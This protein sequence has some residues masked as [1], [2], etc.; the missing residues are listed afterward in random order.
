[1]SSATGL[2]YLRARYY[3]PTTT[4]F[5]SVDPLAATTGEHYNFGS[6]DP[7]NRN[8]PTGMISV[9]F[10]LSASAGLFFG[11]FGQVCVVGARN[12]VDGS[13]T[14]GF[15]ETG[16]AGVQTPSLSAGANLQVS[17]A[18]SVDQLGGPFTYGGL[19]VLEPASIGGGAF[20]GKS[21]G[22]PGDHVI[23]GELNV[24]VGFSALLPT[25]LPAEI[26]GGRSNTLTQSSAPIPWSPLMPIPGI[27]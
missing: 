8:D 3:D 13:L 15:T 18:R 16:G 17:S 4:Q 6:G 24:D 20:G 19:S 5:L 12:D 14:V 2:Y 27:L 25:P 1:M 26:H 11:G 23:G 21:C 10:C 9:G 22:A 7:V